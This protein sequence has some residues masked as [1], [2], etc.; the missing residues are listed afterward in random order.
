MVLKIVN[1]SNT[2]NLKSK[3]SNQSSWILGLKT[4]QVS[5]SIV[6]TSRYVL[7][8][9]YWWLTHPKINERYRN[10]TKLT[11]GLKMSTKRFTEPF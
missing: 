3:T 7:V 9:N 8:I 11:E 2:V 1:D 5:K 6:I 10:V 4:V